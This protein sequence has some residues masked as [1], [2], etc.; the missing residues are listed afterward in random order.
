MTNSLL[1]SVSCPL[2]GQSR[3][4]RDSQIGGDE[5]ERE[6]GRERTRCFCAP[7]MIRARWCINKQKAPPLV[8][9]PP[10][11]VLLSQVKYLPS[12]VLLQL[13]SQQLLRWDK[14]APTP[15]KRARVG[16]EVRHR[17]W[18]RKVEFGPSGSKN[19]LARRLLFVVLA[20]I[21]NN[22]SVWK[23]TNKLI[24]K[25]YWRDARYKRGKSVSAG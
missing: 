20:S 11:L 3:G 5:R 16:A 24:A 25:G 8:V 21:C 13:I 22:V 14:H 6:R 1:I 17:K 10:T 2:V 12:Q 15:A 9:A 19:I 7:I 23:A 18:S 4:D